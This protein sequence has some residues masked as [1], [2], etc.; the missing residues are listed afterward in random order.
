MKSF[1]RSLPPVAVEV[2]LSSSFCASLKYQ[3]GTKA[4]PALAAAAATLKALEIATASLPI[5]NR[6]IRRLGA[7]VCPP[8]VGYLESL[9]KKELG[10]LFP[11]QLGHMVVVRISTQNYG[12]ARCRHHRRRR[13]VGGSAGIRLASR[14]ELS[15]DGEGAY[16]V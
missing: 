6:R 4:R 14:T 13:D 8:P 16:E 1:A 11:M 10:M 9:S 12:I 3:H 15:K 5:T 2:P 7:A